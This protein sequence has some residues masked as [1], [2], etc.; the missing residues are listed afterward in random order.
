[1]N[2]TANYNEVIEFLITFKAIIKKISMHR[3]LIT[4]TLNN[5]NEIFFNTENFENIECMLIIKELNKVYNESKNGKALNEAERNAIKNK[6]N[7]LGY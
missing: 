7:E 5:N 6:L 2:K 3:Y 1:M 4:V